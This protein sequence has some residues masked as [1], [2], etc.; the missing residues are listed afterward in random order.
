[1]TL[2]AIRWVSNVKLKSGGGGWRGGGGGG[3]G[4]EKGAQRKLQVWGRENTFTLPVKQ[5]QLRWWR[6]MEGRHSRVLDDLQRSSRHAGLRRWG[7][8]WATDIWR[9]RDREGFPKSQGGSK[10]SQGWQACGP[11]RLLIRPIKVEEIVL[12][13]NQDVAVFHLF[14]FTVF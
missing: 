3:G 4:W 2:K 7:F 6:W 10:Y 12:I 8:G 13:V 1:M 5:T 9:G 14:S 11:L